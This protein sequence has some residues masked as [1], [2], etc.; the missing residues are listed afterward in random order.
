MITVE[1]MTPID[2]RRNR[3]IAMAG[4][5]LLSACTAQGDPDANPWGGTD[6]PPELDQE[7]VELGETVYSANCAVCH[8]V[9]LAGDP[10]WKTPNQDGS[11]PPPPQDSSGHTWHHSDQA[12]LTIVTDGSGFEQSR[13]PTFGD[14]L[15]EDQIAAVLE[16]LKSKW[17][18]EE[19]AYQ[20][21][22]TRQESQ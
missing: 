14:V 18:P 12:L 10:N 5:L 9:D 2:T 20:W 8:G 22:V 17:G 11:Y 13:M 15:T 19:R 21:Q 4:I 16:Y 6:D 7:M 1:T 3:M